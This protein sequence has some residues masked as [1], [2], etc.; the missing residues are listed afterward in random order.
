M[1]TKVE[2]MHLM[3][4]ADIYTEAY[5]IISRSRKTFRDITFILI[6]PLSCFILIASKDLSALTFT[7]S[8]DLPDFP[9]F[10]WDFFWFFMV[11]YLSCLII[12]YNMSTSTVVFTA[13]SVYGSGDN[14]P[15]FKKVRNVVPQAWERLTVTFLCNFF[16]FLVYSVTIA[17]ITTFLSAITIGKY[18]FTQKLLLVVLP[19]YAVGFVYMTV[20]CQLAS[21]V[22]VLEDSYGFEAMIKSKQLI[23][24]R[25]VMT[26]FIFC[27][28]N[29]S[30]ALLHILFA[31]TVVYGHSLLMLQRVAFGLIC[32]WSLCTL[33]LFG[34]VVQTIVYFVC[35]SYHL[36]THRQVKPLESCDDTAV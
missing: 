2:E 5:R 9:S 10:G 26:M 6:L 27:Q 24:G 22:S 8:G 25:L 1:N 21:V 20:I 13:S 14:Q 18:Q 34:L 19:V 36:E 4:L 33:I 30:F 31:K 17:M 28:L 32:L 23:K 7:S 12:Y 29:C 16:S 11:V 15:S 3:G 35:K